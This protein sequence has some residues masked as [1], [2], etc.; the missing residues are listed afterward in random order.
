MKV[1]LE[2]IQAAQQ[3]IESVIR[4]TP[5]R[6]SESSSQRAGLDV[7]LKFENQQK[8]GSFKLRGAA[9]KIL[10]L[11]ESEKNLGVIASSAGNHAQGVALAASLAGVKS[12]V[13]MPRSASIIKI[14][15][16]KKYGADV[17]LHGD[18]VDDANEYAKELSQKEGY[19]FIHPYKD[20]KVIAGQGTLGLEILDS[21]ED[22]DSIFIP[23]GGGGLISGIATAIKAIRPDC[24]VYG[25]QSEGCAG[26]VESFRNKKLMPPSLPP[27]TIADG[28]AVK[29]PNEDIFE[30]FILPLVDDVVSV[31]D[32]QIAESMVYLLER[33]KTVVEGAGAVSLAAIFNSKV[34]KGKKTCALL[35]GGNVDLNMISKV[36][37]IGLSSR[38]R[39]SDLSVRVSDRPGQLSRL[40][41]IIGEH[42]ANVLE[43]H[44]N[45]NDERTAIQDTIIHFKLETR[46]KE[47]IQE[48]R[49]A[50]SSVGAEVL[51]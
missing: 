4:S 36:I 9:N 48:I 16:T 47:H 35:C 14:E 51:S 19:I 50:I 3:R 44:H 38:G 26:M 17:I 15:A 29:Y 37:S 42:E 40:T 18:M 6:F 22:L 43:V 41:K 13:V 2:D 8:T 23:I 24:K 10:Q 33:S 7:Y 39:V 30:N 34:D 45:R 31:T 5:M 20:E 1:N 12:T 25:V 21:L 11:Q 27:Y 49:D 28:I 46:N 32:D